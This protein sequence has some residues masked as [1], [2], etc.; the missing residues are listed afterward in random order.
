MRFP[1]YCSDCQIFASYSGFRPWESTAK[2][3]SGAL[4]THIRPENSKP[5]AN[6]PHIPDVV[7]LKFAWLR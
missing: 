5:M 7:A 6:L 4:A 2:C 1:F 3:E